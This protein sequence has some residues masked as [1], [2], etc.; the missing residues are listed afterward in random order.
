MAANW[1]G[2][3]LALTSNS[4]VISGVPVNAVPVLASG[5]TINTLASWNGDGTTYSNLFT[6]PLL[7]AGTY[8]VAADWYSYANGTAWSAGDA[9]CARIV[10]NSDTALTYIYPTNFTRPYYSGFSVNSPYTSGTASSSLVGV[11]ILRADG[12]IYWQATV[13]N[14]TG[15]CTHSVSMEQCTYQRIA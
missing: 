5:T 12:Y 7:P 4:I 1:L 2:N 15:A 14:T 13:F 6:S 9:V 3:Q 10:A 8:A 11:V